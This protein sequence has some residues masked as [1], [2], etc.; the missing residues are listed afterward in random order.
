MSVGELMFIVLSI[1]VRSFVYQDRYAISFIIDLNV[2]ASYMS[3][4]VGV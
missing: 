1:S 2:N 3:S 4:G